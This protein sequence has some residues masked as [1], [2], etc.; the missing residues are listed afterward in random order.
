M[1]DKI[2]N[3]KKSKATMALACIYD[4]HMKFLREE[5]RP[6]ENMQVRMIYIRPHVPGDDLM[7]A[8]SRISMIN[9]V[10]RLCFVSEVKTLNYYVITC[11]CFIYVF[12]L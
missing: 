1:E 8:K 6:N 11:Y 7:T 12:T 5:L 9:N 10:K 2:A 4:C 3:V